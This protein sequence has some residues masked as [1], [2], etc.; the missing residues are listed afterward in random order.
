[1]E[2]LNNLHRKTDKLKIIQKV[3]LYS[4]IEFIVLL[5]YKNF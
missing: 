2:G 1:M 3:A 4:N 5:K